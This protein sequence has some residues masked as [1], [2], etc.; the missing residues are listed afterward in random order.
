MKK[1]KHCT[2][3]FLKDE[4][5]P[6][7]YQPIS[8]TLPLFPSLNWREMDLTGGRLVLDNDLQ[9]VLVSIQM[10]ISDDWCPPGVCNGTIT[11]W[12]LH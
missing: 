2:H 10:K 11:V 6:G 1:G 8:L 3:I 5:D 9:R 4:W 7:N 12:D